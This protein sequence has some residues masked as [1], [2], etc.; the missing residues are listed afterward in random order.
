[1]PNPVPQILQ[2]R[3]ITVTVRLFT[4]ENDQAP[5]SGNVTLLTLANLLASSTD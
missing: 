4:E 3:K 5:F 2:R 1:M